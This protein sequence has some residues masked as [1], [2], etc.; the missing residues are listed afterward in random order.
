MACCYS[1]A[2][3]TPKQVALVMVQPWCGELVW[4]L[5]LDSC[6]KSLFGGVVMS[7]VSLDNNDD[8]SIRCGRRKLEENIVGFKCEWLSLT[9]A[10]NVVN[11]WYKRGRSYIYYLKILNEDVVL[12]SLV[13]CGF[14]V[15]DPLLLPYPN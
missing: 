6:F 4:I 8:A 3:Q 5:I 2:P 9:S 12:K 1:C 11:V 15:F 7:W 13:N 10:I 14:G